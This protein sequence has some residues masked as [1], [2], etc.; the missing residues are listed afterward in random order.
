MKA[1]GGRMKARPGTGALSDRGRRGQG[2]SQRPEVRMQK[3]GVWSLG[4]LGDLGGSHSRPFRGFRVFVALLRV[5]GF[6]VYLGIRAG[7][8]SR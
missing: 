6:A 1:E 7:G 4:V 2:R 8:A 3:S 5:V